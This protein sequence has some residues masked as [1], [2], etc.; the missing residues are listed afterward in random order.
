MYTQKK[1][2]EK[3]LGLLSQACPLAFLGSQTPL[4]EAQASLLENE[5]PRGERAHSE[6]SMVDRT[7]HHKLA[8]SANPLALIQVYEGAQERSTGLCPDQNHQQ[9]PAQ[10]ISL[11]NHEPDKCLLLKPLNCG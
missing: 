5:S 7:G 4:E 9:R 3:L 2:L 8:G 10:T 6:V 1:K 11:Q